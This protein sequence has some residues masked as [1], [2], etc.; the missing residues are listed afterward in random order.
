MIKAFILYFLSLKPTHGYEIQKYIQLNQMDEWT[1]IQS[2]SIYYALSKLE[3]EGLIA[4]ER[5]EVVG[6]K[7]RKIYAITQAGQEQLEALLL[8]EFDNPLYDV[9][10]DKFVTYPFFHMVDR[11]KLEARVERHIDSLRKQEQKIENWKQLKTG[12][13]SLRITTLSFEMMLSSLAYQIEWHEAL[14]DELDR[15]IEES[16]HVASTIR[17]LDFSEMTDLHDLFEQSDSVDVKQLKESIL[18]NPEQAEEILNEMIR[19]LKK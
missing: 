18:S 11:E 19:Q 2:G 7:S 5:E 8:S 14:L 13:S 1:K 3:K 4:I 9:G 10:S 16:Q 15:C 6:K 17:N 12:A